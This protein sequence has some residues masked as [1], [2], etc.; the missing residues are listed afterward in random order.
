[1]LSWT[2][3][4]TILL[5]AFAGWFWF[6]SLKQRER[7]NVAAQEAC[8]RANLQFLD[9]T[10]AF[11]RLH[12]WRPGGGW[13]GLRRTYVFDYT[14]RSI[15]RQQGFVVIAG[16]R[17]ETVGFAHAPQSTPAQEATSRPPVELEPPART[18][19]N[20]LDLEEWRR[21]RQRRAP[22]DEPRRSDSGDRRS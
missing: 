9:G 19:T 13:L 10:V 17:V 2:L 7:A 20:V 12:L 8:E 5:A 16:D 15:E 21:L 1:M 22:T 3:L 11:A 6:D 4:A 14:A 18:T